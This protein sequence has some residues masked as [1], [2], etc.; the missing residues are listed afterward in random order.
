LSLEL[1]NGE[2]IM[3]LFVSLKNGFA[4]DDDLITKIKTTIK[5]KYSPRHVPDSFYL[6]SDIPYTISGKKME[7]PFKK[8]FSGVD[9]EKAIKVGA[10]KDPSLLSEYVHLYKSLFEERE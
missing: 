8:I 6:V 10:M 5:N 3:P 9:P 1:D 2:M 4:L 7:T